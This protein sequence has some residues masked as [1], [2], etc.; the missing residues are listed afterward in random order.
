MQQKASK[1][2][3]V[4]L[5]VL[6][7]PLMQTTQRLQKA[8]RERG[9]FTLYEPN[10]RMLPRQFEPVMRRVTCNKTPGKVCGRHTQA[11]CH[12]KLLQLLRMEPKVVL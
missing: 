8:I 11:H 12:Q 6:W 9:R 5:A 4:M 1:S 10:P 7:A 2:G 3:A